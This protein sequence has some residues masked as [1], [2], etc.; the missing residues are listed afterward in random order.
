MVAEQPTV[1]HVTAHELRSTAYLCV[2][3]QPKTDEGRALNWK[4]KDSLQRIPVGSIMAPKKLWCVNPLSGIGLSGLCIWTN[5]ESEA[6]TLCSELAELRKRKAQYDEATDKL[7]AHLPK[8][9]EN[10]LRE[11]LDQS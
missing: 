9:V 1:A 7:C 5:I 8:G 3:G 2:I 6:I 10:L 4:Y 11:A